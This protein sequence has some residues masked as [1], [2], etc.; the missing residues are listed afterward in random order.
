MKRFLYPFAIIILGIV[1]LIQG[2]DIVEYDITVFNDTDFDFSVYIDG[3]FQFKLGPGG[4]SIITGVSAGTHTLEAIS[5]DEVV[6]EETVDLNES[7]E[8]TVFIAKYDLKVTNN[9]SS[10]L[11]IYLDG[12]LQ[13]DLSPRS[14]KSINGVSEGKHT[15]DARTGN[16]IVAS[17]NLD[18]AQDT[19]WTIN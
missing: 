19:E 9:T 6:A 17:K 11:S 14:S 13:F 3:E 7:I 10:W 5:N 18:I 4:S 2:C 1:F 12:I 16:S 15:V 8:W